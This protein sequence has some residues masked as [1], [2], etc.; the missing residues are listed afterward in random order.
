MDRDY[1]ESADRMHQDQPWLQTVLCRADVEAP[2]SD[3]TR[4]LSKR[5]QTRPP[6]AHAR[7]SVEMEKAADH[8][9]ELHERS[10]PGW[11]SVGF[12]QAHVRDDARGPLAPVPSS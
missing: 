5:I 3:G 1:L 2:E 11:G 8:L 6:S 4:E 10:V 12:Y 7:N 9:R